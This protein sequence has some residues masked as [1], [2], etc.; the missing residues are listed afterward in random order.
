MLEPRRF[1]EKV[2]PALVM[3]SF[4]DF[5]EQEGSI[6]FDVK[7]AG[8]WT[9]VFGSEE[10]VQR[11][12]TKDAALKLTFTKKAFDGFVD[13]S[14]DVVAAV[15]AKEVTGKGDFSLL[16]AFGRIL[17]PPAQNLWGEVNTVG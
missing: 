13:G 11:G 3:Q 16:E 2:V 1:F 6:S 5:L 17:R 9:F 10:P 14:L 15:Q 7:D 4:Y 8:Q 12:L